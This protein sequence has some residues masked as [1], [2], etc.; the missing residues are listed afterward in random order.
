MEEAAIKAEEVERAEIVAL[1]AVGH[2]QVEFLISIFNE[3][4]GRRN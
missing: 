4:V 3:I 2:E 1:E